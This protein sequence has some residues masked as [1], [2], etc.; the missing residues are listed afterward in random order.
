MDRA[1]TRLAVGQRYLLAE[2][3]NTST[4]V[5]PASRRDSHLSLTHPLRILGALAA[6]L[7]ERY[8]IP[9]DGL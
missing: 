6:A 3:A 5:S 2:L 4:S 8:S 1:H 9:D 7:S